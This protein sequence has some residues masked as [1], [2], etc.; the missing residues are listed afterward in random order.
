V[1]LTF[2]IGK[3]VTPTLR[4]VHAGFGFSTTFVFRS[5]R[6]TSMMRNAANQDGR[7]INIK[8]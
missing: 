1:Q 4:N 3:Q 6:R 7:I 5:D 8:Q 2:N